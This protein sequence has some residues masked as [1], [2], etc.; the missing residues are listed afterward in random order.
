MFA[1]V[2]AVGASIAVATEAVASRAADEQEASAG[3]DHPGLV[4]SISTTVYLVAVWLLH[5]KS[6]AGKGWKTYLVPAT[7]MAIIPIG[8]IDHPVLIGGLVLTTLVTALST[9]PARRAQ[10]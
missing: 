8:L 6:G 2:A 7:A 4:Y 5:R 1:S 10:P 9:V 3:L